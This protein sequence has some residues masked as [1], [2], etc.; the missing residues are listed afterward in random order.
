MLAYQGQAE[1]AARIVQRIKSV[2]AGA[3]AAKI[4]IATSS[5][6]ASVVQ[7]KVVLA[8]EKFLDNRLKRLTSQIHS[9]KAF[10]C[11]ALPSPP[12]S[13]GNFITVLPGDLQTILQ[14]LASAAAVNESITTASG[15][16][17]DASLVNLVASQLP[18]G[19]AYVPSVYAPNALTLDLSGTT[20]G[21]SLLGDALNQLEGDRN[22]L[23][24]EA[25]LVVLGRCSDPKYKASV[26][27]ITAEVQAAGGLVDSFEASLLGGQPVPPATVPNGGDKAGGGAPPPGS[28]PSPSPGIATT[29]SAT[30]LQQL[31]FADLLLTALRTPIASDNVYLV[32]LHALES[33]GSSLTQ[34]NSIFGSRNYFSG[35]AVATFSIFKNDGTFLCSGISYGYRGFVQAKDMGTAAAAPAPSPGV[36]GQAPIA[37]ADGSG[38]LLPGVEHFVSACP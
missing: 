26:S 9:G 34:S 31:I 29:S 36:D 17:A 13:H 33:G 11:A 4:V 6:V 1:T 24:E 22:N 21:I 27:Q 7:L 12:P 28:S 37:A 23:Y 2:T 20:P 15:S 32:S 5:D 14:T 25:D 35:G 8:Q 18:R 3:P 38:A 16:L 30:A 19:V 10:R